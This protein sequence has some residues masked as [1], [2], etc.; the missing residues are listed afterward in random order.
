MARLCIDLAFLPS[1]PT[2]LGNY[3]LNLL[4]HLGGQDTLVLSPCSIAGQVC[5]RVSP[6]LSS[7]W[8]RRG[9]IARLLWRQSALPKI[10]RSHRASLL[11]SPIPE[12][13]LD[14]NCR[15]VVTVHDLIPLRFPG[16]TLSPLGAYFRYWVP[17]IL[18]RAEHILC[19]SSATAEDIGRFYRISETR[20]TP[21]ALAFDAEHFQ[22][23]NLEV[24][25]YFLYLGRHDAYKNV[26]RMIAAFAW[27]PTD[28]QF[29][30]AGPTDP[31]QTPL[32]KAQV[33]HLGLTERVR[34]LDYVPFAELPALLERAIAL[35]FTTL[36][37]GFGLPVLEAMACGTPV[38][39]SSLSSLPE[40]AGKAALLVD[41]YQVGEIA[42]AMR[43]VALTPGLRQQLRQLG[44]ERAS[45]FS[46]QKTGKQ[47][48]DI[49]ARHG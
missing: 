42:E 3:A 47:T 2:G 14:R 32:L 30:L 4:P 5:H 13:P 37:E 17:L 35:V 1:R 24:G 36:W 25:N 9:H 20:I 41:P 11:F 15:Y 48:A 29:W 43:A 18:R 46:W 10:Y 21:V 12:A 33:E 22:P 38:I 27:L 39:T 44:I 19:D 45:Q 28:Y 8:G 23:R 49:L 40:V 6:G 26:A 16:R 31:N 34:F 7:E